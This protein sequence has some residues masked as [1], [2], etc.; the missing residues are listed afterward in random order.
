[1]RFSI[2]AVL[3]FATTGLCQVAG[4]NV[5]TKPESGEVVPAGS[6]YKIV[7]QPSADEPG[8]ITIGLLGGSSPKTLAIVDTIASK[9][10]PVRS[11]SHKSIVADHSC[12]K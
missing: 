5:I 1:M 2:A 12:T 4:Y 3:A 11:M 10:R 6:T 9:S 7:W 8:D